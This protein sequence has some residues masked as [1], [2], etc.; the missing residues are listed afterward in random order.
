[1]EPETPKKP[2]IIRRYVVRLYEEDSKHSIYRAIFYVPPIVP[3]VGETIA[4]S[5]DGEDCV[6]NVLNVFYQ[7]PTED[8]GN[9]MTIGIYVGRSKSEE[10]EFDNNEEENN[11]T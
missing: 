4:V 11:A 1:M 3:R 9:L 10:L 8:T 7:F 5:I 2:E 6:Y